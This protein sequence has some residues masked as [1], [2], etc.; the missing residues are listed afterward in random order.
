MHSEK[1]VF[2]MFY[3]NCLLILIN[4]VHI[5]ILDFYSIW[6]CQTENL[7]IRWEKVVKNKNFEEKNKKILK[8]EDNKKKEE[9]T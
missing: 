6:N 9:E 3:Q 8:K 2:Y 1:T 4:S 5:C 7:K